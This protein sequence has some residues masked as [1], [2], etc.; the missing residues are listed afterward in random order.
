MPG[1]VGAQTQNQP[2]PQSRTKNQV[3][4]E[5][6]IRDLY[7]RWAKAFRARDIDRIMSVYASSGDA[8]VA[9]AG[10]S[11]TSNPDSMP[12]LM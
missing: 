11:W 5:A 8:V 4:N 9:L 12:I 10:P 6:E 1:L 7:D 3:K 2:T